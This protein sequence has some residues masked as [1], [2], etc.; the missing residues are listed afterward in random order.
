VAAQVMQS[1]AHIS[2]TAM[3]LCAHHLIIDSFVN[4][5]ATSGEGDLCCL[6]AETE[7]PI[8]PLQRTAEVAGSELS[9]PSLLPLCNI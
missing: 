8:L 4:N 1:P 6:K 2:F 3:L 5:L 7:P 9:R